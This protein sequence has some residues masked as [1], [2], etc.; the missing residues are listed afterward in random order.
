MGDGR[1]IAFT[2]AGLNAETAILTVRETGAAYIIGKRTGER[3]SGA[4]GSR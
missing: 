2:I 4:L 1:T 3:I